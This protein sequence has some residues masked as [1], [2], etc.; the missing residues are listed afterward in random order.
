MPLL[1]QN[2]GTSA[3]GQPKPSKATI[4]ATA[5]DYIQAI[6]KERDALKAEVEQLRRDQVGMLRNPDGRNP[7]LDE[8]LMDS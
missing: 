6:E 4:L 7:S 2:D 1:R 3:I 8:Y 5:I